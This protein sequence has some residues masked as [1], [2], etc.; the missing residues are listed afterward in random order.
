MLRSWSSYSNLKNSK[1]S[2]LSR[3]NQNIYEKCS[4]K[5]PGQFGL[6]RFK[7]WCHFIILWLATFS[8]LSNETPLNVG[9]TMVNL[10]SFI[11][12]K[13]EILMKKSPLSQT[14]LVST[15]PA[16]M[17][18]EL[19]GSGP[20]VSKVGAFCPHGILTLLSRLKS[21]WK[22]QVPDDSHSQGHGFVTGSML[23]ANKSGNCWSCDCACSSSV[24][25][26][27]LSFWH[28]CNILWLFL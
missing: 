5:C 15:L 1:I 26:V 20:M 28:Y 22:M 21:L 6:I 12:W 18:R 3:D 16:A 4:V 9:S 14:A 8:T 23:Q 7:Q 27:L 25:F 13:P 19:C 11:A 17:L 2:N 24:T 10:V